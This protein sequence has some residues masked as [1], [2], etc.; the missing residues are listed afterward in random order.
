M[1]LYL[2]YIV[3]LSVLVS[4][5]SQCVICYH[6]GPFQFGVGRGSVYILCS[7][8]RMRE[9]VEMLLQDVFSKWLMNVAKGIASCRGVYLPYLLLFLLQDVIT[10]LA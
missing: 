1:V 8:L 9:I 4:C 3:L 2:L 7:C 10:Y 6:L 5:I